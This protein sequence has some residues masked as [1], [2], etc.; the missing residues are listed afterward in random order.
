MSCIAGAEPTKTLSAP[1]HECMHVYIH[2]DLAYMLQ[3]HNT[4]RTSYYAAVLTG[5]L[6]IY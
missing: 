5:S 2:I 1:D 3:T 4:I 6:T